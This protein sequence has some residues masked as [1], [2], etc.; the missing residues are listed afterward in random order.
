[1]AMVCGTGEWGGPKP[2]DPDNNSIL[3]ATPV[4]GGIDV[5]WTYPNSNPHAVAHVI[6]YRGLLSTFNG[7]TFLVRSGSNV[8]YDRTTLTVPTKYYYWIRI[9]SINGTEGALIG[10]A[11]ATARPTIAQMIE[12]LSGQIEAS[13]LGTSLRGNLDGITL[14]AADIKTEIANRIAGNT[15]LMNALA[16]VQSGLTESLAFINQE[17]LTRQAGE[18]A[19]ITELNTQA[20]LNLD[21]A[22]AILEEKTTRVSTDAAMTY[23]I[24]RS[25]S[26]SAINGA[27]VLG[28]NTTAIGYAATVLDGSPYEG[29]KVTVVYSATKYPSAEFPLYAIDRTR[30]IDNTGVIAWNATTAGKAKPLVWLAG[31]PLAAAVKTI[32]ITSGTGASAK[33]L[34][35]EQRATAQETVNGDLL[36]QYSI[37]IDAA[38]RVAG[39]GLS[40]TLPKAS[41][42][43]PVSRFIVNA[44][45]FSVSK[46]L[47]FSQ[48]TT[49]SAT[50]VGQ[51]WFKTTNNTTYKAN[52][53]GTASWVPYVPISPFVID[54]AT[55]ETY[56]NDAAIKN[57]S[58]EKIVGDLTSSNWNNAVANN[59]STAG[60]KLDR[61]G[62]LY[63]N[64]GVFRG[65]ITGASGIFNG[66]L[67]A[68]TIDAVQSINI[69]NQAVTFTVG[70]YATNTFAAGAQTVEA[71]HEILTGTISCSGAPVNVHAA[72]FCRPYGDIDGLK[73]TNHT[74]SAEIIREK[75]GVRTVIYTGWLGYA[76]VRSTNTYGW[77]LG[78]CS[79]CKKDEPGVGSV[80]YIIR[81][82]NTEGFNG[83]QVFHRSILMSELKK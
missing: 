63:A 73:G 13:S 80:S 38:G 2:G 52:A 72:F 34:T 53:L 68:Q 31:L 82:Y 75:N 19:F 1:M 65:D 61:T 4:F 81:V 76:R 49:P 60:W 11:S 30:I 59:G 25:F 74:W 9:V 77:G 17:V 33:T 27:A 8:H 21:N 69:K 51:T 3:T 66:K 47:T 55:G 29:N 79:F 18:D 22:A 45:T 83:L 70:A 54:T 67:N 12:L 23:D 48:A 46:P 57:L 26:A 58:A 42:T 37:K 35:L 64:S 32:G 16:S 56:I 6:V 20:A 43:N 36:G 62:A 14:N 41:G 24:T 50:A 39:F 40:S 7:A 28:S 5:S 15:A 10:P 71:N 44:D 78:S